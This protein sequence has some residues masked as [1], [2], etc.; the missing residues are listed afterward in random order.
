MVAAL[1]L[2]REGGTFVMK[3]FDHAQ[4]ATQKLLSSLSRVFSMVHLVKPLASRPANSEKYVVARGFLQSM[5]DVEACADLRA[6]LEQRQ[7]LDAATMAAV[8]R[9]WED[10]P[11]E[12]KTKKW[13]N[14]WQYMAWL[15]QLKATER[16]LAL[17]KSSKDLERGGGSGIDQR[18]FAEQWVH[19]LSV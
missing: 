4:P 8:E 12:P 7:T 19:A 15:G 14:E 6:L 1:L 2:L 11:V 17:V 13:L 18:A 16:L 5:V 9:F 10:L 3:M